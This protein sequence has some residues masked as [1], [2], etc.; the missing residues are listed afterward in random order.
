MWLSRKFWLIFGSLVALGVLA[1][2]Y[3]APY[4]WF[5]APQFAKASDFWN[6]AIASGGWAWW[7][8]YFL[9]GTSLAFEWTNLFANLWLLLCSWL[10]GAQAGA[11]VT[12]LLCPA[13]G[14]AGVFVLARQMNP[15]RAA[16]ALSAWLYYFMPSIWA[17]V[18]LPDHFTA[19]CALAIF[20]WCLY[21]L[22]KCV[23]APSPQNALAAAAGI[24]LLVLMNTR[25]AALALP[26]LIIFGTWRTVVHKTF[27]SLWVPSN[28]I[29]FVLGVFFLA[30]VPL[31]PALRESAFVVHFDFSPLAAWQNAFSTKSALQLFDRA[32]W[33]GSEFAPGFANS[34]GLTGFYIGSLG[35]LAILL[36]MF[37][38]PALLEP[39]GIFRGAAGC[40][41][42]LFWLSFGPRSVLG[43]H[44]QTLRD[45]VTGA[46]WSPALAWFLLAA[47]CWLI[48]KLIPGRGILRGALATVAC[49]AY[50][51]LP[52][53]L[54]LGW[55]PFYRDLRAPF[56]FFQIPGVLFL[57]LALGIAGAAAWERIASRTIR[58]SLATL[59]VALVAWDAQSFYQMMRAHALPESTMRDFVAAQ[60]FLKDAPAAGSVDV[61]SG[62]YF[63]L[64]TPL[65]SGRPL[66]NEAFQMYLQQR[67][68]AA[69]QVTGRSS[70]DAR[71]AAE[72][73]S[74]VSF[75]LSDEGDAE[76]GR[77]I[78]EMLQ[79]ALNTP[80]EV[81]A[82][83][84]FRVFQLSDSL[85]PAFIATHIARVENLQLADYLPILDAVN[86][87]VLPL[88]IG[89]DTPTSSAVISSGNIQNGT[90]TLDPEIRKTGGTPFSPLPRQNVI[91]KD[92]QT[93]T[94]GP[95]HSSGVLVLP[96]AWHPDWRAFAFDGIERQVLR[97]AG[98]LPAVEIQKG[99]TITF[100]F[101]PPSW[102]DLCAWGT[103]AAWLAWIL[104]ALTGLFLPSIRKRHL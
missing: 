19:L 63:Y 103:V 81:F 5:P 13:I 16:T 71:S 21:A 55:L 14:A 44:F 45:S 12:S 24:G 96:Q 61:F 82:N 49:L 2:F 85:A 48:T 11:K 92:Y 64:L 25:T 104:F 28:R 29:A 69:I 60:E 20:P 70:D 40:T 27:C 76:N 54:L 74:G 101:S 75:W 66:N 8:P 68:F 32:G 9:G 94:A 80:P 37:M 83:D 42:F 91:R 46:D 78:R 53:F 102:Y 77:A 38:R 100:L 30:L 89:K 18:F 39:G 33:I 86:F 67:G 93:V 4:D 17:R 95:A 72:R 99:E 34:T 6:A 87:S 58:A 88:E 73:I 98:G 62:R 59:A 10:V 90:L 3:T 43:A 56:D 47:Q 26:V 84:G 79:T 51:L 36:T 15:N 65:L 41:L 35:V 1:L 23:G 7:T 97:A 22:E 31:L 52:G 57:A 50:L